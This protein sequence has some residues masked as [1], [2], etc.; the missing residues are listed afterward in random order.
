MC[1]RVSILCEGKVVVSGP[2]RTLLRGDVLRTDVTLASAPKGLMP[3]LIERGFS[4]SERPEVLVVEVVGEGRV[5][6]VLKAALEAGAQVVEVA[7][8]RETLEDLFLR[9]A[10]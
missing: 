8:R 1:D 9:Q 10:I 7:P 6:E 5:A 3:N 4:V 2:L